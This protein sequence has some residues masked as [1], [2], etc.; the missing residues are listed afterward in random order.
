MFARCVRE[1]ERE[2]E[3]DAYEDG[4][5]SFSVQLANFLSQ[6]GDFTFKYRS[7]AA[8]Q[9]RSPNVGAPCTMD[10]APYEFV[11]RPRYLAVI[12]RRQEIGGNGAELF[13]DWF[14]ADI[15]IINN[16]WRSR[17]K[18]LLI[19]ATTSTQENAIGN[20]STSGQCLTRPGRE[21]PS[22]KCRSN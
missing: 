3:R 9:I 10:L 16:E 21:W 22:R 13:G 8:L 1:R 4:T 6:R 7:H 5:F 14:D 11:M 20:R 12:N 17:S 18:E 19:A 2:R 15:D